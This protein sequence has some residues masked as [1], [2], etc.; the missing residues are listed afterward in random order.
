M[1]MSHNL[2]LNSLLF[3]FI[4]P[5]LVDR[6][7]KYGF[8]LS[9]TTKYTIQKIGHH[10]F[11][12]AVELL[13]QDRKFVLVFDNIDWDVRAHEMHSDH[14]N[15]SVHA[16]ATSIVFN[17]VSSDHLPDDEPKRNL[18]DCNLKDLLMLTDE[19]KI[20]TRERYK[21]F[22]GRIL[23]EWFPAF[24]FFKE[25]LPPHTPCQYQCEMNLKSVVVTLPVLLKDE[26]KYADLVEVLAQ[27]QAWVREIYSK[28]GLCIPPEE[29]H[30]PPGPPIAAP[31]RPDQPMSHVPPVTAA[32]DPLSRVRI[33]CFGD[34][35][36][37]VRLVGAKYLRAG[38]HTP[39]DRL[40]HLYPFRIVDWH[41]KR[42]FLK[43]SIIL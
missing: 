14:Q 23:C 35:L 4:F 29:G 1:N 25:I 12:R 37:R 3:I 40:D 5:Q 8:C 10:F 15:K 41:T 16:M 21:I 28:A 11:D 24:N 9:K 19:E 13:K 6:L 36:T 31:S 20:C 39:Q 18:A 30:V 32:D 2:I 27:L 17:R 26:K 38:S 33:P 22:L 43:V 42:S 7:H 34:Q